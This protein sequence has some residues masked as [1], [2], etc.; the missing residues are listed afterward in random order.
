MAGTVDQKLVLAGVETAYN[1]DP[2][3]SATANAILT[4]GFTLTPLQADGAERNLDTPDVGNTPSFKSGLRTQAQFGV[5]A[6][7]S[8]VAGT[9]P[10][11][12]VLMRSAGLSETID[13]TVGAEKVTYAPLADLD[14]AE[15]V[16][17]YLYWGNTLHKM[18]GARGSLSLEWASGQVPL[19]KFQMTGL[20]GPVADDTL[21]SA[22][23]SAFTAPLPANATNTPVFTINGVAV[24]LQA[25]TFNQQAEVVYANRTG[26]ERVAIVRMRPTLEVTVEAVALSGL[27]PFALYQSRAQVPVVLQHGT[28]AGN[29]VEFQADNCEIEEP[30]YENLADGRIG[31][32]LPM[33]PIGST[34]RIIAR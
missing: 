34:W 19:I 14:Q 10:A 28:S 18:G 2:A 4:T 30:T 29:I 13:A 5:E 31:W 11:W 26:L 23:Y 32:K 27:D 15:S 6:A 24:P 22:D 1:V 17:Q 7:G 8:G 12:G 20:F 21:P 33:R 25:L 16:Y 9:A 3:L